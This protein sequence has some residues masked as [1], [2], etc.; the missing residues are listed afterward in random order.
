MIWPCLITGS[1]LERGACG[2]VL[3]C[4]GRAGPL[5]K[6]LTFVLVTVGILGLRAVLSQL[7]LVLSPLLQLSLIIPAKWTMLH[8]K[9]RL[10]YGKVYLAAVDCINNTTL[11]FAIYL[12]LPP[13]RSFHCYK[14]DYAKT[15]RFYWHLVE[16]W[17]MHHRRTYE[18]LTKIWTQSLLLTSRDR[19]VFTFLHISHKL[20]LCVWKLVWIQIEIQIQWIADFIRGLLRTEIFFQEMRWRT[21][22][23]CWETL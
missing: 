19:A 17:D 21:M 7:L 11:Q 4:E 20:I 16:G 1:V 5:Q 22:I 6:E 15:T 9:M 14:Q 10:L 3:W 13:P 8:H 12:F 18:L 23:G 2:I